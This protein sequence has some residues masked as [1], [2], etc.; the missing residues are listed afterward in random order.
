MHIPKYLWG[1][2]VLTA[3]YLINQIPAKVLQY[4]SPLEC[5]TRLYYDLPIK[6][7]G[8]TVYAHIPSQFRSK[9]D[10]VL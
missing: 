1:K 5:L 7:F 9:L 6:V 8:R 10:H 4:K 2:A 3:A